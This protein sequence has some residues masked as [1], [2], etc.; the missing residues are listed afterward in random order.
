MMVDDS[1]MNGWFSLAPVV[2]LF[3]PW[4]G[5]CA[6]LHPS[7]TSQPPYVEASF[8]GQLPTEYHLILGLASL[9]TERP[10]C[11]ATLWSP[12]QPFRGYPA[13]S[14]KA[15]PGPLGGPRFSLSGAARWSPR[16]AFPGPLGGPRPSISEATWWSPQGRRG[17]C[18]GPLSSL[19][20]A[21]R[22]SS[23]E[24]NQGHIAVPSSACPKFFRRSPAKPSW[25]IWRFPIQPSS[26]VWSSQHHVVVLD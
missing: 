21:T 20:G 18:R 1:D 6:G 17:P 3:S 23:A 12:I 25:A 15:R 22:W 2:L 16:Q 9:I 14:H 5:H 10:C 4:Q 13:V 8:Q 11:V 26:A 19:A 24:P 7:P